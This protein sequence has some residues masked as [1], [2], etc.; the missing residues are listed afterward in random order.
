M[1]FKLR[2]MLP[3][4]VQIVVSK[5]GSEEELISLAQDIEVIICTRLSHKVAQVAKKLKLIQKTGA[6]VDAIPFSF[7]REDVFVAN[8]SG[9]NPVPLAEGAVALILALAKRIIQ[10]HNSF[11]RGEIKRGQGVELRGKK[12]GIIGLGH[13]GIE[14]A[15]L[16]QAFQMKIMALKRH[17]SEELKTQLGLNFLGGPNDLDHLLRESDFIVVTVPSTSET[18]GMI[19]ERELR[20]MKSTAFIVNI[21]RAAII[22]EE[23]LYKALKEKWIAG[24]A[25][26][27]WWIPHWWDSTWT[28]SSKPLYQFWKLPNVI[29]TPHNIGSTDTSSDAGLRI[30]A[31]NIRRIYEGKP[32]INKVDRKL[33][34]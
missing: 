27:V 8:T 30:I 7:L 9:A 10:R 16:L 19:G 17:P 20:M 34:Y 21:A 4:D 26:D 25:I 13:I 28:P 2:E 3:D 24:A 15:R 18:R 31:E 6:G 11:Q 5:T 14:V 22:Q 33:Q 23:A 12:A 29:A 32:P 1:V